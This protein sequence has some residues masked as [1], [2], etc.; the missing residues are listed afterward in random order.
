[1]FLTE[2]HRNK[3]ECITT[4]RKY[5]M[6]PCV[7]YGAGGLPGSL[8]GREENTTLL[9]NLRSEL[10]ELPVTLLVNLLKVKKKKYESE[11]KI[12][13][14]NWRNSCVLRF[15]HNTETVSFDLLDVLSPVTPS[16]L[17]LSVYLDFYGLSVFSIDD[18]RSC[19]S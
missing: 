4:N 17:Y 19:L 18:C 16:S 13:A 2:L 11:R 12:S 3:T 15:D 14:E 10:Q 9:Y 5:V 6:F 7:W 1:M 8:E